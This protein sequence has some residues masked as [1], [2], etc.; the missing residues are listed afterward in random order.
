MNIA[1]VPWP[2][3][4]RKTGGI[5]TVRNPVAKLSPSGT[6]T[7]L[8]AIHHQLK[9]LGFHIEHNDTMPGLTVC[10]GHPKSKAPLAPKHSEGYVLRCDR[11]GAWIRG[12]DRDG[13]F[14]G[15]VTLEQ[16][17]QKG[18][19]IPCVDIVDF[20][21]FPFRMHHDDISRKQVSTVEDFKC[22]IRQLSYY[23]IKYYT[24]Y[25]EDML[26]LPS[27]PDIGVGRGR[28]MPNE[29]KAILAEA[30]RYNV[31]VFPTYSLM[32][33]QENLLANPKYRKFA[34]EV[35]Q[36]PSS[37]DLSKPILRP[38]LRQVIRDVCNAF[39]DAP[40]FHAGFDEVFGLTK[41]GLV[42][43][44]NWCAREIAQYGKKM[45]LYADMF[46][47]HFGLKALHQINSNAIPME[48]DYD[49]KN[50]V[51]M[52]G[53]YEKEKIVPLGLAGYRNWCHFL[54][55]FSNGKKSMDAWAKVMSRWGG[56][57]FGVS[58]WG[59][60]GYE[61]S[62]QLSANLFAYNAETAWTGRPAR[63][64]FE[65]RFQITFYGRPL[66]A[67]TRL[68][69]KDVPRLKSIPNLG[70]WSLF[71]QSIQAM[72]RLVFKDPQIIRHAR[73]A[74]QI[75]TASL[76][77]IKKCQKLAHR[78]GQHI[79]H[80]IVAIRR[81]I[82]V[83]E[84]LIL[85][86]RVARGLSGAPLKV[87][88]EQALKNLKDVQAL[89][90]K[91][92]LRHNKRPNI[93]VSLAVYDKISRSLRELV[94]PEPHVASKFACLDITSVC[95][96]CEPHV[97]DFPLG[98][99]GMINRVPFRFAHRQQTHAWILKGETLRLN[100]APTQVRDIHLLYGGCGTPMDAK[101]IKPLVEVR[102]LRQGREVFRETLMTIRHI[103]D[104][105]APLG[106]HMWG[107]GGLRYTDPRRVAYG[108]AA[109]QNE[110]VL[111]LHHFP[112]KRRESDT[113]EIRILGDSKA[114]LALF[115]A[116]IEK[117]NLNSPTQHRFLT[118]RNSIAN[119]YLFFTH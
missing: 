70:T 34:K 82:N 59:D 6:S 30:R 67:L 31:T 98:R 94:A 110:G 16:L 18:C 119:R 43:H 40:Y 113:L 91:I 96:T 73:E 4:V 44:V 3:S 48:W 11:S 86:D 83:L 46:K 58:Q 38:Y 12:T 92:W 112:T 101:Q 77:D 51:K 24:P 27:H 64:D 26:Y 39:P 109:G 7:Q 28:L 21:A 54:P 53:G 87:A 66:P 102:L 78:E 105:F 63:N 35:F 19:S 17:L 111:H 116:T 107:G 42:D 80:F 106:E 2:V 85:A 33:H 14:W 93:E 99:V 117:S 41:E 10:I 60:I 57:G 32:G 71:R 81:E 103:C 55:D 76:R 15:L 9:E 95:N 62:R 108:F 50:V 89:Y 52:A 25:M 84:R 74:L 79:D 118:T 115:A 29:V 5:F 90:T 49:E 69:Q 72:V 88:V 1:L 56:P 100:F 45:I 68:I 75:L 97:G 23:K 37:Y 61:N 47:G 13:L 22:I 114:K 65:T 8:L 104:W 36:P 20:P